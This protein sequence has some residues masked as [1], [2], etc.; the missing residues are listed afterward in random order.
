MKKRKKICS[1]SYED[2]EQEIDD[3]K[4]LNERFCERTAQK[5]EH[6]TEGDSRSSA[7]AFFRPRLDDEDEAKRDENN[8]EWRDDQR[9]D[10]DAERRDPFSPLRAAVFF[11]EQL[12]RDDIGNEKDERQNGGDDPKRNG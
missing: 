5:G 1:P 6:G 8:P 2:V 4:Q 10:D 11:D 9:A 3:E 7:D 12:I